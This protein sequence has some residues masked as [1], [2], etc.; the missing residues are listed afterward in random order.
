MIEEQVDSII[1]EYDQNLQASG[2]SLQTYLGYMGQDM[3]SFRATCR[4]PA[5][6][7]VKTELLLDKIAEV[8]GIEVSEQD[9]E[10]EYQKAADQYQVDLEMVKSSVPQD[11]IVG[12]VK[13]RRAAQI[14]FDNGVAAEA[15]EEPKAEEKPKKKS[16][17][18]KKTETPAE[19]E[20]APAAEAEEAPKPKKTTRKK[21]TEEAP[22]EEEPKA[23]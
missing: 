17:T 12:D 8:E 20:Q 9:I 1:R 2:L 5:E 11:A 13:A 19:A 22:A 3:A 14:I 15:D 23:E 7:R 18:R 16:T 4:I 6:R 10:E 21:K